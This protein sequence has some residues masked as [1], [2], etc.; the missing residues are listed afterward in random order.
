MLFRSYGLRKTWLDKWL[1]SLV[2]EDPSRRNV[3]RD[4]KHC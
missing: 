2:S 3:V 4:P 1:E